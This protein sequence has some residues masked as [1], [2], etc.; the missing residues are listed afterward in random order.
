MEKL[1]SLV[2]LLELKHIESLD[3]SYN[4][5]GHRSI[6][7]VMG[8]MKQLRYLNLSFASFGGL[9]PFDLRNLTNL[10]VL[11]MGSDW[12]SDY[13]IVVDSLGW[14]SGLRELRYLNM[15]HVNMSYSHDWIESLIGP[16]PYIRELQLNN[17]GLTHYKHVHRNYSIAAH[18]PISYLDLSS[19]NLGGDIL[20]ILQNLT[21]LE[22]LDLSDSIHLPQFDF[23]NDSMNLWGLVHNLCTLRLLDLSSNDLQGNFFQPRRNLSNNCFNHYDLEDLSIMSSSLTGYIPGWLGEE[24]RNLKSIG[25]SSNKLSDEIPAS[26]G[27]LSSLRTLDLSGNML[28]GEIPVS[29]GMLSNLTKLDLSGNNL[30]SI[31]PFPRFPS[32]LETLDLSNNQFSGKIPTSIGQLSKLQSLFLKD[33]PLEGVLLSEPQF[34][35]LSSLT[36]LEIDDTLLT[37]NLSSGW[38]PPFQ[39]QYFSAANCKINGKLPP[40]LQTQ[41]NLSYLTLS[42]ANISGEMPRWFHTMQQLEFVDLSNN[43]LKGSPIFPINFYSIYLSNNSLSRQI[44]LNGRKTEVYLQANTINLTNNSISEPLPEN[45]GHIMPN[46]ELLLLA[47]NQIT[48]PIPRSLC[49]LTSLSNLDIQN[50]R[51]SGVIPNCWANI[52]TLLYVSLSYNKLEGHIPCFN[53]RDSFNFGLGDQF[54]LH[55]NDNMLTGEIPSCLSDLSNLQIL[56]VGGNQLSGKMNKW[57]RAKKF[58][59]LKIIRLR[60]NKFSGTIPR[61]IC[62]LPQ[63][64]LV[65]LAHNHFTGYIPHCLSNLTAMSS[66]DDTFI[67]YLSH[68]SEVYQGIERTYTSSVPYLVDIDLSSNN[69]MG[70]IPDDIT[71]LSGLLSLNLS[72]NNLSGTIPEN[73]GGLK[74][75]IALDL[76]KNKLRGSIPTSMGQLYKLSQLNLSYNNLSGEIPTGNQLQT[77]SD[78]SSIYAGN[79]YLCGDFMPRKC[80][81]KAD[82]LGK[83]AS[84][85][86]NGDKEKK[87]KKMGFDLVVVSGFATGFWGVVGCL[88][89]N[90]RWRHEF[91]RRLEDGYNWLYVIVVLKVRLLK[92][93]M[94]RGE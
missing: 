53:N 91:F 36:L 35:S 84:D 1:E 42:N 52:S 76:S 30:T 56:D 58:K 2:Y 12:D 34:G 79:P 74:S 68:V 57:F 24:F 85:K 21:S 70:S 81:S 64:Q 27:K 78:Q 14:V 6:P 65:D 7:R 19:N 5:F 60:G 73:I 89:L 16:L 29:L 28:S 3:L 41:K 72:Y 77:L 59:E 66:P 10:Q 31:A 20:C 22:Y 63:L 86:G 32:N 46:L 43:K 9:I 69:L 33:N 62:S 17:C 50:N 93:K 87:L 8:S 47:N 82:E 67:A 61:Q 44:M 71:K 94:K 4:N 13:E 75:L 26:L 90:S 25:L 45:L 51:L 40:W 39:L 83:G 11:D 48:G 38:V 55:L 80:K 54:Y 37:L 15:N 88:V 49:Q 92:A 23:S 18:L